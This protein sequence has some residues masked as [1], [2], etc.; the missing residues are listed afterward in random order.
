MTEKASKSDLEAKKKYKQWYDQGIRN[1]SFQP[2]E[3][4]LMLNPVGSSKLEAAYNGPYLIEE[5]ISPVTYRTRC[6]VEH[7][8]PHA[9][10]AWLNELGWSQ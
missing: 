8:T 3:Y 4:V 10:G 9:D 1:K 2:G 5:K 7:C 6:S